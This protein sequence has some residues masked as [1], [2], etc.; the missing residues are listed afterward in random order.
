T[1][2]SD[3]PLTG[4]RWWRMALGVMVGLVMA[5]LTLAATGARTADPVSEGF[6]EPAVEYGGG[7]HI[8]NVTLVDIRAWGTTG[9]SSVLV[10]RGS[11]GPAAGSGGG[12]TLVTGTPVAVRGWDTMGAL[13][14]LVGAGTGVASLIFLITGRAGGWRKSRE[15]TSNA[16]ASVTVPS[17]GR[18][19]R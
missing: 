9:E 8:V 13:S 3:R 11:A 16:R 19:H 5:G 7:H 10:S 18:E 12:R 2:F 1:Y 14:V 15:V 6:A 17:G 4:S